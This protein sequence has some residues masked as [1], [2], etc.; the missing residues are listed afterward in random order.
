MELDMSKGFLVSLEGPEGSR[1]DQ[2]FR[3]S[4]GPILEGKGVEVLTTHVSQVE[5]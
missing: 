5:S 4:K 1:K 3:G 2:C